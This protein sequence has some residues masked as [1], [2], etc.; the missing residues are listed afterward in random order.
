MKNHEKY[1]YCPRV[2]A[3]WNVVSYWTVVIT[4]A[5]NK[6]GPNR[7]EDN[8]GDEDKSSNQWK[9]NKIEHHQEPQEQEVRLD[10]TSKVPCG[11]KDPWIH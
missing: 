8:A 9:G 10:A 7:P 6:A 1:N 11:G 5:V 3:K 2:T 4:C